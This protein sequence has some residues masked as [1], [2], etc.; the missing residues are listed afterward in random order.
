[1]GSLR[2]FSAFIERYER[3]GTQCGFVL[4]NVFMQALEAT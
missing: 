4:R 3:C 1:V 2:L